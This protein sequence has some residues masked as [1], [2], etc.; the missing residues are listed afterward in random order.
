MT[1]RTT[2]AAPAAPANGRWPL[3][4]RARSGPPVC[5]AGAVCAVGS[6]VGRS[7]VGAACDG[8]DLVGSLPRSGA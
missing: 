2:A 4:T 3:G 8:G 1:P 6:T 7:S 5:C